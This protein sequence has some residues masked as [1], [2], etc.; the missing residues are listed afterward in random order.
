MS[1]SFPSFPSGWRLPL[2]WA[3]IDP[4]QAGGGGNPNLP[5]LLVGQILSSGSVSSGIPSA[6]GVP[7]A[8]GSPAMAISYFGAG[9]ML[10][11]MCSIF[12]GINPAAELFCLPI[13]DSGVG[14]AATATFT[15]ATN[16]NFLATDT[17]TIG[18]QTFNF[19]S[20]IGS[21]AGN[22]LVSANTNAGF[23]ATMVNII[24]SMAASISGSGATANYV[25]CA[26]P[27][28]VSGSIAAGNGLTSGQT[29]IFTALT[30][31]SAGN[32][33]ASTYTDTGGVSAGSFGSTTFSGGGSGA[34]VKATGSIT[35]ASAASDAGVLT[36]Y[37]AGQPVQIS[38]ATTDA[39][40]VVA[41]NLTAAITA[42]TS[43]PVSAVQVA[44]AVNL[45]CLWSGVTGNDIQIQP[46]YLGSQNDEFMPT[47]MSVTIVAMANGAG[48]PNWSAPISNLGDDVYYY[49]G[50]PYTDTASLRAWDTEYGFTSSGRWGWL[51]QLYG[52]VYSAIRGS[53]STL[54]S[55][56]PTGNSGVESVMGVE[57]SSP[58]PV[59]EWTAA[60]TAQAMQGFSE[61][62]ARPLQTLELTGILPALKPDRWTKAE[63]NALA[64]VGVAVQ[65]R[66]PNGYPVIM[67][68]ATRYQVNSFG[69]PDIA[70]NL[71]T[72]LTT[73]AA[74]LMAMKS[75]ITSKYPRS[76]LADDGTNFAT[77][78]AIVTPKSIRGE[79]ISEYLLAEY[80]GLVEDDATF[81][82]NLVV[83]RSSTN[84]NRVD[85]LYPPN[86]IGQLRI[87]AVLA[88]FRLLGSSAQPI[89]V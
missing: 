24:A 54:I 5:A 57:T 88:Q 30:G 69:T 79:I 20:T 33:L 23:A 3:E 31:G 60:Y 61:D 34:G 12:F 6:V 11:D 22:I 78:Q 14:S 4:S 83:E 40:S 84:P 77:G 68:E 49:T 25:P 21:T 71:V 86:L 52:N 81:G 9:S 70:Y 26:T 35:I 37:I 17:I 8:V 41:A 46:N 53:Y 87:F 89:S 2:F 74:L 75:A 43:L 16:K 42:M 44:N 65:M 28:N 56:G 72:T 39:T 50:M 76:K 67:I 7:I 29:C 10:A 64:G 18:N 73:L 62:P 45:T 63:A 32:S 27:S 80:N 58:S 1:I 47:G 66:G 82:K 85:V 19:V 51:R 55:W 13:A 59:W 15:E 48:T 38:V 36:I